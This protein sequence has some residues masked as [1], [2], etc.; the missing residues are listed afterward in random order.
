MVV[1]CTALLCVLH[2]KLQIVLHI[3]YESVWANAGTF[4]WLRLAAGD[5]GSEGLGTSR[6]P[7]AD[8]S[9]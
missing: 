4:C 5:R 3:N 8:P 9:F 2:K 1:T 6:S 7:S